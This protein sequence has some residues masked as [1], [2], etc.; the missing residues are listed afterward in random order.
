VR[1][2]RQ[3]GNRAVVDVVAAGDLPDWFTRFAPLDRLR[4]LA[5]ACEV[6]R[7]GGK[8]RFSTREMRFPEVFDDA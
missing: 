6:K 2:Q 3:P 4:L 1:S 5:R 8:V 7:A